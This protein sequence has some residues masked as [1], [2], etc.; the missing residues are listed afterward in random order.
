MALAILQDSANLRKL[1]HT[2]SRFVVEISP[3]PGT[4]ADTHLPDQSVFG[5]QSAAAYPG[6][7]GAG[8]EVVYV[9]LVVPRHFPARECESTHMIVSICLCLKDFNHGRAQGLDH[10]W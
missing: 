7:H 3:R 8:C 5:G 2:L 10:F 6:I 4:H 9:Q 1:Q